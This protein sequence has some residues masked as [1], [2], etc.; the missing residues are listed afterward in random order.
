[1]SGYV[2]HDFPRASSAYRVRIALALKGI[3]YTAKPVDFRQDE[4]SSEAYLAVNAAGLVPVLE[5]PE[6][7][8]ITQSLAIIGYLDRLDGPRL[9]P[10]KPVDRAIVDAMALTVACD[11]HPLN[12]LRILKYLE[13]ELMC[14]EG[15]RKRWYAQWVTRGFVALEALV[16]AHGGR[17][18]FGD[19]V[20]AADICLVPQIYNARRFD[21]SLEQF[22]ALIVRDDRLRSHA[23]FDAVHPER[24]V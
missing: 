13:H 5:T 24:P 4:Q 22:P 20:S 9:Y 2:L 1:M 10:E 23:A 16:Q 8:V 15:C 19:E 7:N 14:D 6:G 17:F 11:I 21:V 12:N 18:C 3:E